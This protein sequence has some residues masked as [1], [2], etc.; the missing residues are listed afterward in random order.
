MRLAVGIG[1]GAGHR[2]SGMWKRGVATH[3]HLIRAAG[4]G[5]ERLWIGQIHYPKYRAY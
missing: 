3:V 1:T 2:G 5:L 4:Y